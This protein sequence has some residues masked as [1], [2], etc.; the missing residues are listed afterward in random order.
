MTK[1][2][3]RIVDASTPSTQEYFVWDDD[4]SGFGLRVF[5]SGKRSYLIQ[6]RIGNRTRRYSIGMHG[7]WTPETARREALALL[8]RVAR[9]EDP[10]EERSELH[11]AISVKEFCELYVRDLNDGLILGKGGRPKKQ[12]TIDTDIGRINRHIIPL[13]GTRKVKDLTKPILTKTMRDMMAGKTR[14][15]E[16]SGKL[17]GKSI[18]KGGPGTAA[19]TLGL[20]GGMLTYAVDLGLIDRNPA[21]GIKKPKDN[22]R[23]RRLSDAEYRILGEMLRQAATIQKY[24]TTVEVIR[25]LALTGCRRGEILNLKWS[26]VDLDGSCLRLKDTKEG[27]SIRPIG[28]PVV[29]FLE[30]CATAP[31]RTYIFSGQGED[32]P[33]GGFYNHWVEIFAGSPLEGVTPHVLRHSFASVANDLGFTEVTIAALLGHAKGSVTS[34]YIHSLDAALIMGADTLAGYVAAL[35]NGTVFHQRAYSLDRGARKAALNDFIARH[36]EPRQLAA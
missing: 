26:D 2:T 36:A 34:N 33:F 20:L 11:K 27:K 14:R 24:E 4:L 23:D 21:H 10:A 25:Q 32:N 35:L 30:G 8:G 31:S 5:P 19:R 7:V 13:I 16:K 12:S 1:L 3:K 17:R 18:V 6:Y 22:V 9:G 29:E 15:C 28:L